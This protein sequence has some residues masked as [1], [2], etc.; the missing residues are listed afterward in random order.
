MAPTS[1]DWRGS[2]GSSK[3][4]VSLYGFC[5]KELQRQQ[6][7]LG[8]EEQVAASFKAVVLREYSLS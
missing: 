1:V 4:A 3:C 5:R 2:R 7:V 6:V 8:Q